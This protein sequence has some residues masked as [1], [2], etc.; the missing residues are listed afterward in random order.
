MSKAAVV[1]ENRG[2]WPL[3]ENK[4]VCMSAGAIALFLNLSKVRQ[5]GS[6]LVQAIPR[7]TLSF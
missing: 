3:L 1:C 7:N 4:S 2:L 5:Q 6:R